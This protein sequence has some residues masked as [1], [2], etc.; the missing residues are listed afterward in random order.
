MLV[1]ETPLGVG[2]GQRDSDDLK[3]WIEANCIGL[4]ESMYNSEFREGICSTLCC[5]VTFSSSNDRSTYGTD[6]S[7]LGSYS[8]GGLSQVGFNSAP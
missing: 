8:R 3:S 5:G 6:S 4:R 1:I 2:V 7:F